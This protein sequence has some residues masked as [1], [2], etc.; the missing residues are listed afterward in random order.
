MEF[1]KKL[2]IVVLIL[3][4][5]NLYLPRNSFAQQAHLYATADITEHPPE[6]RTTPQ[7][8][9]PVPG[10]KGRKWGWWV[11]GLLVVAGGAA[12]LGGGGGGGGESP[13][14]PTPT[15][16]SISGSW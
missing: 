15:D 16:G 9:I 2:F 10:K 14:P 8:D 12:A 5:V 3:L 7:K 11:L 13:T 4:L 1:L 6:S